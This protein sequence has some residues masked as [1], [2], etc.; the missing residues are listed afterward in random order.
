MHT[1]LDLA[2]TPNGAS[3]NTPLLN[4]SEKAS[5]DTANVDKAMDEPLVDNRGSSVG[6]YAREDDSVGS[7]TQDQLKG[8]RSVEKDEH[9]LAAEHVGAMGRM[10]WCVD[11]SDE[12]PSFLSSTARLQA[13]H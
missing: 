11:A 12:V 10:W 8:L 9:S 13:L 4:T 6:E 1:A 5:N 7:F 2:S 3:Q